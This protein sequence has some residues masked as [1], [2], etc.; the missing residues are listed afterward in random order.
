MYLKNDRIVVT[1]KGLNFRSYQLSNVGQ[2]V[3]D[4][5]A[6]TGWD[7]GADSRRNATSRPVTSGDF[8]EPYT[9]SARLISLSGAAVATSRGELQRMRDA[10]T[11]LFAE[12]EYVQIRVETS[13]SVRY[14]TVGLEN[15]PMFVQ[16][17]DNV[18]SFRLELYAPDP[19]LY[20]EE[21]TITLGATSD[22]GG[23]LAYPLAYP[24]NYN[25]VNVQPFVPI[26][27]NNGNSAA[28]PTFKVTGDYY[29]G[30]ILTDGRDKQ[31]IY[32]GMVS[33]TSP[34]TIDMAKG[35]ASQNGI[36]KTVLL[37][38]REWFNVPA[39]STIVPQFLPIQASSG[40]CDIIIR[41]TFI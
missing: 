23:G 36:D 33:Q 11:S 32:N 2:F 8:T 10:F 17:L 20:G 19:H 15:N 5:T 18:A 24:L 26:V 38:R 25:A 37:S 39:N 35:T 13:V 3:L 41:D 16:Q 30:F 22:A 28:W 4:A 12:G 29:S 21:R 34:V 14:A 7:D 31:V 40:W 1:I 27:T 9:F 6:L